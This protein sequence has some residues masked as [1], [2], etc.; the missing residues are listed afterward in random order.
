MRWSLLLLGT[1]KRKNTEK[2]TF[3]PEREKEKKV[4]QADA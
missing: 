2:Q 1:A 3:Y 4:G